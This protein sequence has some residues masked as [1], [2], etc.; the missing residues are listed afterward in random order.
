MRA[1]ILSAQN[2]A[3]Q[4]RAREGS[5]GWGH[6]A[7]TPLPHV[8]T[9]Y[10]ILGE[11]HRGGQ[12]VVYR[13]VQKST[14]RTVAIKVMKEGPFAGETSRLRFEREVNI[15]AQLDHRCIIGIIDR[16]V[17]AGSHF[18]VMDFVDGR[19]L[20]KFAR[21]N[22]LDLLARLRLF[23]AVCDAVS[24]AHQRGVIHRDLKP[25]N[26]LV[27]AAGEPRILDFGLAKIASDDSAAATQ[28]GQFLGS[29]PWASPEHFVGQH[30]Q[31][32]TRSDVY[33]L[34]IILYQLLTDRFPYS[35]T[36]DLQHVL[37]AI[38]DAQPPPPSDVSPN[39]D[40]DLD[41]I[42]LKC[43]H[44]E[45]P[46]RYQSVG[47]LS[48]DIQRYLNHEPIEA[49]RD[50]RWYL[51]QRLLRKHRA[52]AAVIAAFVILSTGSAVALSIL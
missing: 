39:I 42:A 7:L 13:G 31:T 52:A 32:D 29:L 6:A 22:Q 38:R 12:G 45:P 24:A 43:L 27:N 16:G 10:E 17:S 36:G 2:A 20:D 50:S 47:E 34:G 11:L 14:N 40:D 19:P 23:I 3:A 4:V 25:G 46:Q 8:I 28:T 37:S 48:R 30:S 15:L 49:K 51:L 26:I 41:A 1:M 33:S 21:D 9:G 35:T 18:L 44:K 5:S